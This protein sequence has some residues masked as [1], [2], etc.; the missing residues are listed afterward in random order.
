MRSLLSIATL[1]VVSIYSLGCA[2]GYA[3]VQIDSVPAGA[4][5]YERNSEYHGG[6]WSYSLGRH[7]GR[8]PYSYVLGPYR[9]CSPPRADCCTTSVFVLKHSGYAD[10]VEYFNNCYR[11][12]SRE[13]AESN[14]AYYTVS[15][16]SE[17]FVSYN[18]VSEPPGAHVYGE[19]GNYWGKAPTARQWSSFSS[20]CFN[21]KVTAKLAGYR[22]TYHSWRVCP[23][24]PSE[25][26]AARMAETAMI[27]MEPFRSEPFV[28][29]VTI[30]SDPEGVSV[31]GDGRYWG[32]TPYTGTV[33][34]S[35]ST[36]TIGPRFEKAGW[37]SVTEMLSPGIPTVHIVM[38]PSNAAPR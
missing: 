22:D 15:L 33:S 38:Q 8:T 1:G 23:K 20:D 16:E 32:T 25:P 12:S 29:S 17:L 30:T 3:S 37:Q 31:F 28:R 36:S 34:W 24:Y 6:T 21:Y 26:A 18:I 13:T 11:H 4:E 9:H 2:G 19:D 10:K 7:V 5:V 27:I 35:S 14:P